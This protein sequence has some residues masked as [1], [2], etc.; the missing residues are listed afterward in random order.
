M[1]INKFSGREHGALFG[2]ADRLREEAIGD[3]AREQLVQHATGEISLAPYLVMDLRSKAGITDV[4]LSRLVDARR[5]ERRTDDGAEPSRVGPPIWA[6]PDT[7]AA[8][9]AIVDAL[10]TIAEYDQDAGL[11]ELVERTPGGGRCISHRPARPGRRPTSRPCSTDTAPPDGSP[12]DR[13]VT[14]L[15]IE[16]VRE[17]AQPLTTYRVTMA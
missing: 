7:G 3:D 6:L 15:P 17:I 9:D 13:G 1:S 5:R 8:V 16:R 12:Q 10:A 4:G 11:G 2:T 14:D